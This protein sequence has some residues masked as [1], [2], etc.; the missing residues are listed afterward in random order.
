MICARDRI[1][2]RIVK[3]GTRPQCAGTSL[4]HVCTLSLFR[5]Q[6]FHLRFCM[7]YRLVRITARMQVTHLYINALDDDNSPWQ[8]SVDVFLGVVPFY[9]PTWLSKTAYRGATRKPTP[10]GNAAAHSLQKRP[11]IWI[12]ATLASSRH[13]SYPI[14][15]LEHS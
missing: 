13:V 5:I 8:S 11:Q 15:R 3:R 9:N 7:R 2:P 1:L 6:R 10:Y 14:R 12:L 4:L